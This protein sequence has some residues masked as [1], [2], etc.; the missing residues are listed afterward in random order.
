MAQNH[1]DW[2]DEEWCCSVMCL[3]LDFILIAIKRGFGDNLAKQKG[4]DVCSK[5]I[6]SEELQFIVIWAGV[7]RLTSSNLE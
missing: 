6:P 7:M 5:S 3:A 1:I 2:T 4:S